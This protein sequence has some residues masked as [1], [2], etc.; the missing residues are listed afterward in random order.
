MEE[1]IHTVSRRMDLYFG[2]GDGK[3][4]IEGFDN[5]IKYL[6]GAGIK[7]VRYG[8]DLGPMAVGKLA[9]EGIA[10]LPPDYK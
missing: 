4:S 5:L 10:V 9:K 3:G 2:L 8:Y 7:E 1:D 6:T